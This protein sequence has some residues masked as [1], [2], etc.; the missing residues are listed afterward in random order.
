M[1]PNVHFTPG[2]HKN[3][4]VFFFSIET[5]KTIDTSKISRPKRDCVISQHYVISITLKSRTIAT[6]S[7]PNKFKFHYSC[8]LLNSVLPLKHEDLSF[9][10]QHSTTVTYKETERYFSF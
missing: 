3:R 7:F 4:K 5:L 8:D 2:L 1:C 6:M 9:L 10:K